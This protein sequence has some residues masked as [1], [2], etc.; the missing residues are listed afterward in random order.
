MRTSVVFFMLWI[1]GKKNKYHI[2]KNSSFFFDLHFSDLHFSDIS[3]RGFRRRNLEMYSFWWK[4]NESILK[5]NLKINFRSIYNLQKIIYLEAIVR[6]CML[7][8]VIQSSSKKVHNFFNKHN[9]N[10]WY[11]SVWKCKSTNINKKIY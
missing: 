5:N 7:E 9:T 6:V 3:F 4:P 11:Q 2:T 1:S 8:S 10:S